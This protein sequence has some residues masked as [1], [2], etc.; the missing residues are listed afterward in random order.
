[1]L[2]RDQQTTI[3]W[4]S[5]DSADDAVGRQWMELLKADTGR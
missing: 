5:T 1:M 2:E 4:K 3:C